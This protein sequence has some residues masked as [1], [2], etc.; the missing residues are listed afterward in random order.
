MIRFFRNTVRTEQQHSLK[1]EI[2]FLALNLRDSKKNI[3]ST[4]KRKFNI[5]SFET[6]EFTG[7]VVDSGAARSCTLMDRYRAC[8]ENPGKDQ[9]ITEPDV[10]FKF[11]DIAHKHLEK[12]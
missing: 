5:Q 6:N 2:I 9:E 8:V 7:T 3:I 11:G 4:Q 10:A 12:I 1:P